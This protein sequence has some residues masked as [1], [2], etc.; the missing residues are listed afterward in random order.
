MPVLALMI[1]T[2]AH[3]L[4]AHATP[5][6]P[7]LL[8]NHTLKQCIATVYLSDECSY[9]RVING[10]EV[11]PDGTCPEGY[12]TIQY[13][14]QQADEQRPLDCVEV[15][16]NDWLACSWGQYPSMTP[17]TTVTPP[18]QPVEETPADSSLLLLVGAGALVSVIL[19]GIVILRKKRGVGF[20][21]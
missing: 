12:Q 16:R 18:P 19:V 8:L 15:P 20:K 11:S 14:Y 9:C 13:P 3:L 6:A 10:W 7:V 2:S 21:P 5:S 1:A 4:N 17:L